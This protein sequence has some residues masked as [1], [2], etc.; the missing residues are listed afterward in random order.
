MGSG[1]ALA[2]SLVDYAARVRAMQVKARIVSHLGAPAALAKDL[3]TCA[4]SCQPLLA[5]LAQAPVS[6]DAR[7]PCQH[8]DSASAGV[9]AMRRSLPKYMPGITG[10]DI[11]GLPVDDGDVLALLHMLPQ[12]RH[13]HA[14]A[15]RKLTPRLA[16]ALLRGDAN[17]V[18]PSP[19]F[20]LTI[21][22]LQRCFQ[23]TPH[24]LHELLAAARSVCGDAVAP[25]AALRGLAVSHLDLYPLVHHLSQPPQPQSRL[26]PALQ[27]TGLTLLAANNCTGLHPDVIA[28]LAHACPQLQYLMLGGCTPMLASCTD[29]SV[30][31]TAARLCDALASM[32]HLRV[33]EVTF[34]PES[35]AHSVREAAACTA[36]EVWDFANDACVSRCAAHQLHVARRA[37]S[38]GGVGELLDEDGAL[39]RLALR[40]GVTCSNTARAT[41]LHA[42]AYRGAP[43]SISNLVKLGADRPDVRDR[44]GASPLFVACEA[45]HTG[46]VTALLAA[47][48]NPAL[49]NAS[50]EQP[51]YIASL[52]GHLAAV[53]A[54]LAAHASHGLDWTQ[55]QLYGDGWTPLMAAAVAGRYEVACVLLDAAAEAAAGGEEGQEK[56]AACHRLVTHVN[57]YGQSALHIAARKAPRDLIH[58]LLVACG[59]RRAVAAA[60]RVADGNGDM[61]ADVARKVGNRAAYQQLSYWMEKSAC[62]ADGGSGEYMGG[63]MLCSS[64]TTHSRMRRCDAVRS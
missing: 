6:L 22:D 43:R 52:R 4:L 27:P 38:D 53:S 44:A 8:G 62:D 11:S 59:E 18:R 57:R 20:Q 7:P 46:C 9:N 16:T 25:L 41:P 31:S 36:L 19:P 12:L 24:T 35:I 23:L 10:L 61:P 42:A 32:Q 51:L 60:L 58:R 45:G 56:V 39:L 55:R 63:S 29:S 54:L 3:I 14:A 34:W 2:G 49:A 26:L 1:I 33:V 17:H 15:C 13:L 50:G 5:A 40:C 30:S 47:G 64:V 28:A 21:L 37:A 48:A